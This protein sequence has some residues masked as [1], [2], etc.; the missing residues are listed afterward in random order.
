MVDS[1]FSAKAGEY[2]QPTAFGLG[3]FT[4]HT[5]NGGSRTES[6]RTE[7]DHSV[8]NVAPEEY[9]NSRRRFCGGFQTAFST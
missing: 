2:A 4:A 6:N 7:H 8:D 9:G 5:A 3:G 1:Y